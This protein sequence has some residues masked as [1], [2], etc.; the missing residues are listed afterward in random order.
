MRPPIYTLLT[1]L[2]ITIHT[3]IHAGDLALH[4]AV[5]TSSF[6]V[7]KEIVEAL[8]AGGADVNQV[9][10]NGQTPLIITIAQVDPLG[11][12]DEAV[13]TLLGKRLPPPAQAPTPLSFSSPLH[14]SIQ[15]MKPVTLTTLTTR[16]TPLCIM[17]RA[18]VGSIHIQ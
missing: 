17:L 4:L 5:D 11:A 10:R 14:P 3:S 16:A 7:N 1:S 2:H 13:E 8:L 18:I 6:K 15:L 9:D 12:C